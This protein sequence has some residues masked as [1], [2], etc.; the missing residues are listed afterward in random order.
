ME[1]GNMRFRCLATMFVLLMGTATWACSSSEASIG[2]P[3]EV[4]LTSNSPVALGD[5]LQLE[6]DVVGRSLLGLVVHWGDS[7][8]DSLLF[9]GAQSAGGRIRHRYAAEGSFTVTAT[10]VDQIEGSES[11]QLSVTVQP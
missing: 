2:G 10:A 7:Q 1:R 3:L 4:R 11:R 9:S 8:L 6:Y 5:S